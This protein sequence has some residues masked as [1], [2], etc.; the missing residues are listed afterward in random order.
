MYLYVSVYL[1]SFIH[2]FVFSSLRRLL[3]RVGDYFNN[4]TDTEN[5]A[6]FRAVEDVQDLNIKQ[7][8]KHHLYSSSPTARNDIALIQLQTCARLG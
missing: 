2:K 1:T 7:V 6:R 8:F 5:N 4:D 3:V